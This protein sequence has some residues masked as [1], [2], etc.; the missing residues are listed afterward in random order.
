MCEG[1]LVAGREAARGADPG[2][3]LR[4]CLQPITASFGIAVIPHH[5]GSAEVLLRRADRAC[6]LAKDRGRN[7]VQVAVNEETGNAD[8]APA[9]G[10]GPV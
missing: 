3:D 10:R 7:Q 6:Y 9:V 1:A 2:G 8:L 5:A 4:R